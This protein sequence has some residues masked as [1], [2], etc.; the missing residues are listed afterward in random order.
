MS[1]GA[2]S[3]SSNDS[4]L[5]KTIYGEVVPVVEDF[6]LEKR[7]QVIGK[8]RENLEKRQRMGSLLFTTGSKL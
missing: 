1:V 3:N 4:M 7:K 8:I 2:V 6:K 5:V